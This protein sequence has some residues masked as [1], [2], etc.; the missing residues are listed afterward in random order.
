MSFVFQKLSSFQVAYHD[1]IWTVICSH[2]SLGMTSEAVMKGLFSQAKASSHGISCFTSHRAKLTPV[3]SSHMVLVMQK[4]RPVGIY[5]LHFCGTAE[6]LRWFMIK[7]SGRCTVYHRKKSF[8]P[9]CSFW[10]VFFFPQKPTNLEVHLRKQ[11]RLKQKKLPS[12]HWD[13]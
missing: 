2:A 13:V 6:N 10:N 11:P 5:L 12:N 8:K 4:K 1:V 7:M 9:S 3:T